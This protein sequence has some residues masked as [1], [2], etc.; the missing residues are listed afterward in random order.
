MYRELQ[1]NSQMTNENIVRYYGSWF[2]ELDQDE[3]EQE[4]KYREEYN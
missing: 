2:E 4:I 1:M 3:K